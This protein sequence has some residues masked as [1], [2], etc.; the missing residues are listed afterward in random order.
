MRNND[1]VSLDLHLAK[2]NAGV[3]YDLPLIS[4]G[5]GRLTV[6][7]NEK[8]TIPFT[9]DAASGEKIATTLNH[10]LMITH[11]DYLPNAAM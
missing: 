11:W 6:E 2:D 7:A 4:L 8:V 9:N 5:D 10:T 1:D 3:S